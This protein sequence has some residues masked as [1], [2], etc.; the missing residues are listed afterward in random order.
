MVKSN[1]RFVLDYKTKWSVLAC[2]LLCVFSLIAQLE[3]WM[4]AI[5]LL[6][7][8]WQSACIQGVF[9]QPNK[10]IVFVIAIMG[11]V[12]IALNGRN[13]GLLLSMIH[14]ISFSYAIKGMELNKRRDF[15][16]II[17]LGIFILGCAFI[18]EQ[19]VW[20]AALIFLLVSFNF[21]TLLRYFAPSF[22]VK[23]AL[24]Q[25]AYTLGLSIP[26]ALVMFILFPRL[27]PFWQMP[28]AKSAKTGLGDEVKPGDIAN[29]A[30]SNELAFRVDFST[31]APDNSAMY[32][33]AM[34]MPYYDGRSWLRT[35]R[36]NELN[37][38]KAK[39][40][41]LLKP[42]A[43]DS[44]GG[45]YRYQV[46][47]EASY[48]RWLF[49][50]DAAQVVD[51]RIVQLRDY[52]LLSQRPVSKTMAYQVSSFWNSP[53][54]QEMSTRRQQWHLQLPEGSNPRLTELAKTLRQDF[55]EDQAIIDEVLNR[56]RDQLYYYTL[57]PPRLDDN[58]LDQFYFDTK[59]GFCEHYASSFAFIMRAAGIPARL[60]T[61]YLGGQYN[62]QGNYYSI[63]QYD[64]HA[65]TEVWLDGR[66]WVRVDPTAAVSPERVSQGLSQALAAEK[67]ALSSDFFSL[68]N[69]S[70]AAWLAQLTMQ[71][72]AIDYQWT[73]L[74]VGYSMDKQS[75]FLNS[76][77][78]KGKFWKI[79]LLFIATLLAV[80]GVLWLL[81]LKRKGKGRLEVWQ[82]RFNRFLKQLDK[83]G[84]QRENNQTIKQFF[85]Q[86]SVT[87]QDTDGNL[88]NLWLSYYRLRYGKMS[89]VERLQEQAAL[90]QRLKKSYQLIK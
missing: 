84:Y 43:I 47:A 30:R 77:L 48:Q 16:Q 28:I 32:W 53:L 66:G 70:N 42:V 45:Q 41:G 85:Q 83:Q 64:A 37:W 19:S 49:A 17:L 56:F 5:L 57:Q 14:L 25:N 1:E 15:Y 52:S 87:L 36:N 81:H 63:Y 55:K 2:Q 69:W 58:N 82:K 71:F 18:F 75:E 11:A 38:Q 89:D 73:R 51:N 39:Q 13:L 80:V 4:L 68:D 24:K 78:G 50:L 23:T 54:E 27:E 67:S 6:C 74:V 46:I 79:V 21:A 88:H 60:V 62:P 26:L 31:Q 90:N 29:L 34:T 72:E 12:A 10:I 7:F 35:T 76:L 3:L 61:G 40:M 20:F 86:L 33:R 59:A 65:W 9:M 44:T 22:K 8:L